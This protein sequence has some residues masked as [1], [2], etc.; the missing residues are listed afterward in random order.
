MATRHIDTLMRTQNAVIGDL[1]DN[2]WSINAYYHHIQGTIIEKDM[3]AFLKNVIAAKKALILTAA[4]DETVVRSAAN[5]PGVK[6]SHVG[7]MNVYEIINSTSFI[8]TQDAVKK[9]EEV[10]A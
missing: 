9:I 3:I 6:V 1:S 5:I 4:S 8:L 7:Q 2:R 10:Y